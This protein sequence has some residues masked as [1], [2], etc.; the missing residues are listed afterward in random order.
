MVQHKGLLI[1]VQQ[2][3]FLELRKVYKQ[4]KNTLEKLLA[5]NL[6]DH[7]IDVNILAE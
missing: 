3:L 4:K 1:L 2:I 6:C 5:K 7:G